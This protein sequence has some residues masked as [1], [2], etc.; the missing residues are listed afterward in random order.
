[1]WLYAKTTSAFTCYANS[2]SLDTNGE[3][4]PMVMIDSARLEDQIKIGYLKYS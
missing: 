1:M 3:K 2:L 4:L